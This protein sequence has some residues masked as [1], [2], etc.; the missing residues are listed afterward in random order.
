M[1]LVGERLRTIR[2]S[3]GY[4]LDVKTV[5]VGVDH[6]SDADDY[7]LLGVL[8]ENE[9]ASPGMPGCPHVTVRGELLVYGSMEEIER[10]PA[11]APLTLMQ[12]VKKALFCADAV[13]ALAGLTD[14]QYAGGDVLP[15]LDGD[16]R[17][18]IQ[19]RFNVSWQESLAT[20]T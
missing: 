18:E 12:N 17:T 4:D 9:T 7:P 1:R 14:F 16:A 6:V 10:D 19:L 15:R 13:Q 2:K 5:L 11:T 20:G 8:L 3:A